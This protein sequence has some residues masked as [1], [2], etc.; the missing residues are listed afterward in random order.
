[1][2]V[3]IRHARAPDIPRVLELWDR[4]RSAAAV[5]PDTEQAIGALLAHAG[6]TV[7]VAE[8]E[9]LVVGSLTVGWDGWRGNM[10]RLAVRPEFRR[11]GIA[12]RLVDVGHAHL[13]G[14]GARRLTALVAHEEEEAV[15]VWLSVGY[16]LDEQISRFVRNL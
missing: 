1:M 5:T 6:S 2:E 3:A 13:R 11:R 12:R 7:L 8:L 16:E 14:V 4:A 10:Y 15:A 9:D